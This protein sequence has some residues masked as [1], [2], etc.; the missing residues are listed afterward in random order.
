MV[1]IRL[2]SLRSKTNAFFDKTYIHKFGYECKVPSAL[3]CTHK[4][5]NILIVVFL[6]SVVQKQCEHPLRGLSRTWDK[7]ITIIKAT[8]EK[9]FHDSRSSL[10]LKLLL[11]VNWS[12]CG[13][14]RRPLILMFQLCL[15]QSASGM[16]NIG[17]L[18]MAV[19]RSCNR[20]IQF[21][22]LGPVC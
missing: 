7:S 22:A 16:T 21:W 9:I 4:G 11:C 19:A 6:D 3:S 13:V 15:C 2:I 20:I 8:K 12:A 5:F 18:A 17:L 14:T 10:V 1:D